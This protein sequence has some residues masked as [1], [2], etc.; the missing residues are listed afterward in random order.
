MSFWKEKTLDEMTTEEWESLCD[1]CGKCCLNKLEDEETG[2][3]YYTSVACELIDL[4]TCS[5]TR[6]AQRC[7]LVPDCLDLKQHDFKDFNWLPG[8]CAYK[9]LADGEDLP[10]WHPL[11]SGNPESV[12]EAGVA[13]GSYAM[14]ESEV[15]DLEEHI[16]TWLDD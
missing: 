4:E 15:D 8:T 16:I 14:K 6:Y 13:I 5:C 7:T 3:I 1:H 2:R 9:L 10:H 11:V 12:W